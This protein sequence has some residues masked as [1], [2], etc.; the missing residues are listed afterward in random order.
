MVS[1]EIEGKIVSY[2]DYDSM[3]KLFTE[4]DVLIGHNITRFD[5][6]V[7]ERLLDIK[8]KAELIDTLALSWY[9]Y[10]K[11]LKHGLED[12][13]EYFGVPKP[14]VDDWEN[15][16]LE[17]YVNRCQEDV[18]INKNLWKKIMKDLKKLYNGNMSEIKRLARYLQFK[19]DCAREQER[20]QWKLDVG[21]ARHWY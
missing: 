10:P 13:G 17:E 14:K 18:K 4:A 2:T 7:I 3:R 19:M 1:A 12:W 11:R 20:S 6:P 5:I 15:L 8:V 16:P 9:L 21:Q